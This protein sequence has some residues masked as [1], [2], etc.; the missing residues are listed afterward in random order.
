MNPSRSSVVSGE[1]LSR[2][3]RTTISAASL[4]AFTSLFLPQPGCSARPWMV[5][6][7]RAAENVSSCS[8]PAVEPSSV[9]AASAP[10]RSR[11]K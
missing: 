11:S 3:S 9:Y 10:K 8:S 7:K 2:G 4:S 5:T 6:M 1:R